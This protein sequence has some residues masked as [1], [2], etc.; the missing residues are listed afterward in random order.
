[1]VLGGRK[2]VVRVW[3]TEERKE[4][5]SQ[6]TPQSTKE[7]ETIGILSFYDSYSDEIRLHDPC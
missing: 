5:Y 4:V 6:P 1:M 3:D 2:G 7:E